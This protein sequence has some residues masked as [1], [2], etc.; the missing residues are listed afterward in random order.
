MTKYKL[1]VT[2]VFLLIL[3]TIIG[4]GIAKYNQSQNVIHD[5]QT[6]DNVGYIYTYERTDK[7]DKTDTRDLSNY[8]SKYS[9]TYQYM[10][11]IYST[12]DDD[13]STDKLIQLLE[14][15][16]NDTN[17]DR[18]F[19]ASLAVIDKLVLV[20]PSLA[21]QHVQTMK[22]EH[23]E[24]LVKGLFRVWSKINM[25]R[26][27]DKAIGLS[28]KLRS[29][30]SSSILKECMQ[31][32]S[33]DYSTV[34]L[35]LNHDNSLNIFNLEF[36][37]SIDPKRLANLWR[38]AISNDELIS[39][40]PYLK[41]LASK[42]VSESG[43]AALQE[44]DQSLS[45]PQIKYDILDIALR[46]HAQNNPRESFE[47]ALNF[48][49]SSEINN[50]FFSIFVSWVD[51]NPI[52]AFT[53]VSNVEPAGRRRDF[54][55]S[56]INIWTFDQPR[57]LLDYSEYIPQHLRDTAQKHA[58]N[59]IAEEDPQSAIELA[60]QILDT[61]QLEGGLSLIL[62]TWSSNNV[63]A[64]LD[65]LLNHEEY[66]TN[67]EFLK[68]VFGEYARYYPAKA[69]QLTENMEV[70]KK[71]A[72]Q[73]MVVASI[74]ETD[75]LYARDLLSKMDPGS[76]IVN[77]HAVIRGLIRQGY[78]LE[79]IALIDN[80]LLNELQDNSPVNLI[81]DRFTHTVINEWLMIDPIDAYTNLARITNKKVASKLAQRLIADN[82]YDHN[83][84]PAAIAEIQAYVLPED[85][86]KVDEYELSRFPPNGE[87]M[88]RLR[89]Q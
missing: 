79:A 43:L 37:E 61:E 80:S 56:I 60:N 1:V 87:I 29:A 54:Q 16:E 85:E 34:Y 22:L 49:I 66:S 55:Q 3:G 23:K 45:S 72:V 76:Y 42:W 48:P 46:S 68:T 53:I 18:Q 32:D 30:A 33:C 83:F 78:P 57:T 40:Q 27:V 2:S 28:G 17:V 9:S 89:P 13:Q 74:S 14:E 88:I 63:T 44:I 5:N 25:E 59:Q 52:E 47:F 82:Q 84:E 86:T 7:V 77:L 19:R 58:L 8:S 24:E 39:N 73:Q 51:I 75:A 69:L 31:L 67:V 71:L 38:N 65:W 36:A 81:Q 41:V 4:Y 64:A 10:Q 20:D 12:L 50:F 6:S 35:S 21:L 26:A 70:T 15:I 11:Y 62:Q